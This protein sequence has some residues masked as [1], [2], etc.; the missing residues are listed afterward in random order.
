MNQATRYE[1]FNSFLDVDTWHTGHP[2][3]DERFHGALDQ[4]VENPDFEPEK[5]GEYMRKRKNIAQDDHESPLAKHID[6]RT[7]DAWAVKDHYRYKR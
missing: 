7:R 1:V 5:M 3:D 4:V 6:D 2:N